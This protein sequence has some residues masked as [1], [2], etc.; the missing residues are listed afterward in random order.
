MKVQRYRVDL[1]WQ[2]PYTFDHLS[3]KVDGRW[4]VASL[5]SKRHRSDEAAKACGQRTLERVEKAEAGWRED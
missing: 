3:R 4:T 5:C 1:G 2:G